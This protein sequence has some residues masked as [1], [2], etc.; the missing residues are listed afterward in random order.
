MQGLERGENRPGVGGQQKGC[1]DDITCFLPPPPVLTLV[2]MRISAFH[3]GDEQ[4]H[5]NLESLALA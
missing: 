2:P 5:V 1:L 3:K 4:L